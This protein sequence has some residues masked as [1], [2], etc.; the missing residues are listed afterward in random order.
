MNT[1]ENGDGYQKLSKEDHFFL[2]QLGLTLTPKEKA[3]IYVQMRL[4]YANNPVALQQIDAYDGNSEFYKIL[5][6]CRVAE[7]KG[8]IKTADELY[9]Q[10]KKNYPDLK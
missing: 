10:L 2:N 9:A 4:K 5:R 1:K 6:K 7:K 3:R 8:D